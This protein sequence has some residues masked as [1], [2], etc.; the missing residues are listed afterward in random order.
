MVV[1]RHS[2]VWTLFGRVFMFAVLFLGVFF[3]ESSNLHAQKSPFDPELRAQAA[4]IYEKLDCFTDRSLYICDELIR[5][6][7]TIHGQVP[8]ASGPWSTVLYVELVSADGERLAGGKYPL[9]DNFAA[10]GIRIPAK[11]RSGSYYLR[12]YTRWM[13]NRGPETYSYVP[14]RIINPQQADLA[15][16]IS[17]D[18][19]GLILSGVPAK[20]GNIEFT[21]HQ[22]FFGRGEPVSMN[23]LLSGNDL[24]DSLTGCL[25]V[26]PLSAR[27]AE[28]FLGGPDSERDS[29]DDFH[30]N[31]LPDKYGP[32]ISGTVSY[33][34]LEVEKMEAARIHFTLIGKK[35]G[36]FV[37][38]SDAY[39]RFVV[40]LPARTGKLE[41]FVQPESP[42]DE[43]VEV[44]IDQDFDPRMIRLPASSFILSEEEGQIAA[45]MS[46]NVQLLK[47]YSGRLPTTEVKT[48]QDS[49]FQAV[50]FYGT[51]SRSIDLDNYVMLPT[52]KEV[53]LN[54]VPG[55]TPVT[56][57]NRT[58]LQIYSAN[59]SLSLYDPLVMI[60]QVPVLDIDQFMS[61]SPA[62]IRWVDVLED[63][64]VK[65]DLRFGGLINLRSREQ[66][67]AG[68]DL[69]ENSFFIDYLSMHPSVP[70][71]PDLL[72]RNSLNPEDRIPDTRNTF[73][74]M[75]DLKL[76]KGI[77]EKISFIAPDYPGEYLVLFR[78]QDAHGELIEAET[79][80]EVR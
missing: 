37:C 6:R 19:A 42:G 51:P 80:F 11:L 38:R 67:M 36:Y 61:V 60:D 34:G 65:G 69:P 57:R 13:R 12:S 43:A 30:L 17:Q 35:S 68:I 7:A 14:L 45:I 25:T 71:V 3:Q 56:R 28:L 32:S 63:V 50:P 75:A 15:V 78:G 41:L 70:S 66:D 64:Y 24:P 10:G 40:G 59:P 76:G 31:F 73:L 55:V 77:A 74:W 53:F 62:K 46:R 72:S 26:V 27:P 16:E 8:L 22:G 47:I 39:G 58:T 20:R 48:E 44:R 79:V 5:F 54:L 4:R 21:A 1:E 23:L 29:A 49:L 18:E 9:R 33:P 2:R 52:L